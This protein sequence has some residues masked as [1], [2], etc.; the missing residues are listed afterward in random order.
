[1]V[2]IRTNQPTVYHFNDSKYR[3][4]KEIDE[5]VHE[6]HLHNIR[7]TK[8]AYHLQK[9]VPNGKAGGG[10]RINQKN[11]KSK[12]KINKTIVWILKLLLKHPLVCRI[13]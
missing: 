11:G 3:L 13:L 1:M 7:C 6:T 5:D 10:F 9:E 8:D 4:T 12:N 2:L